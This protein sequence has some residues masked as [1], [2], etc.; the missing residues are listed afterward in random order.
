MAPVEQMY[1]SQ[2]KGSIVGAVV[3]GHKRNHGWYQGMG[4]TCNDGVKSSHSRATQYV[5]EL[6]LGDREPQ[7]RRLV[8]QKGVK[9]TLCCL[10]RC[11]LVGTRSNHR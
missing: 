8:C 5:R 4:K 9:R 11:T 10:S 3:I 6:A 1:C 7:A 2:L